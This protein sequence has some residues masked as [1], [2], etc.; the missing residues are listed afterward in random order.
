MFQVGTLGGDMAQ[1]IVLS[2]LENHLIKLTGAE[3]D[4]FMSESDSCCE[5]VRNSLKFLV[6]FNLLNTEKIEIDGQN[7][8]VV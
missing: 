5:A 8:E 1:K 6:E 4:D 2:S 3:H 7:D